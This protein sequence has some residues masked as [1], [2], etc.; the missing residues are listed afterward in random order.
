[1][2]GAT[3]PPPGWKRQPSAEAPAPLL[4]GATPD[5]GNPLWPFAPVHR[6]TGAAAHL[7]LDCWGVGRP[8][9]GDCPGFTAVGKGCGLIDGIY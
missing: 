5:L 7:P 1:M 6:I 3:P 9:L 8:C 4:G 2:A